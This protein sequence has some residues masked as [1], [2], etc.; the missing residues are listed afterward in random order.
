[1]SYRRN[2]VPCVAVSRVAFVQQIQTLLRVP[3]P[4]PNQ[5]AG[6][7]RPPVGY[8]YYVTG[9]IAPRL[10]ERPHV[11][12]QAIIKKFA[13]T[14]S[15]NKRFERRQKGLSNVA[16]LRYDRAFIIMATPGAHNDGDHADFFEEHERR[17]E[18][19][20]ARLTAICL[21]DYAIKSVENP[22]GTRRA[23]VAMTYSKYQKV[24]WQ[25]IKKGLIFDRETLKKEFRKM[26]GFQPFGGVQLQF[27][28]ILEDVNAARRKKGFGKDQLLEPDEAIPR[29]RK[30][31]T[32]FEQPS[33]VSGADG[34]AH[35]KAA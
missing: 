30:P 26:A 28:K 1:M 14:A 34:V 25:F 3:K 27:R 6:K 12:D 35:A 21:L 15:K 17:G 23:R 24:R 31:V 33:V 8:F 4:K 29:F 32:V 5:Q 7:K 13:V 11:V 22:D 18:L 2:E 10:R 20:D 19:L 16:Y 9:Y